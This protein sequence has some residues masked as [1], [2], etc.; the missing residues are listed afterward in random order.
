MIQ[1]RTSNGEVKFMSNYS[2]VCDYINRMERRKASETGNVGWLFTRRGYEA[3]ANLYYRISQRDKDFFTPKER[4]AIE[5]EVGIV[6]ILK[7]GMEN[8]TQ[9]LSRSTLDIEPLRRN[10]CYEYGKAHGLD[11]CELVERYM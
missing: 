11:I 1:V 6:E 7:G 5:R 4:E 10:W 2:E 8:F 9:I 3:I